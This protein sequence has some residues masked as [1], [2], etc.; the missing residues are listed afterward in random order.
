MDKFMS[1]APVQAFLKM[2]S[3]V[4]DFS[5][6]TGRSD[7]WWAVLANVI[8][9]A[10]LSTIF[11]FMGSFGDL[12]TLFLSVILFALSLSMTIRRLHD[13]GKPAWWIFSGVIVI[14]LLILCALPGDPGDNIYGADPDSNMGY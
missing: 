5:G 7:F 13:S 1:L 6:R 14:P 10:V 2:I 12:M 8:I 4:L 3:N 11:N 9:S